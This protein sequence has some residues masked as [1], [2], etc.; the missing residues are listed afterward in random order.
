LSPAQAVSDLRGDASPFIGADDY[1]GEGV[2]CFRFNRQQVVSGAQ[3]A[4]VLLAVM[5]DALG[6]AALA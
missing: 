2:P 1:P 5:R 6:Q 4:S 3:P